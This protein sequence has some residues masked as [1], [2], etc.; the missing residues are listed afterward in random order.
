[1]LTVLLY[2]RKVKRMDTINWSE[3]MNTESVVE[4]KLAT[5]RFL[6]RMMTSERYQPIAGEP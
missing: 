5:L 2:P 3:P 6:H 1:V 4:W